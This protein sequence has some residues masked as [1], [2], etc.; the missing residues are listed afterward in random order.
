MKKKVVVIHTGFVSV[1]DLKN[2]FKELLPEVKMQNIVDDSLLEEV[3]A[4]GG[5]TPGVIRRI[6]AYAVQAESTGADLI[7]N[8]C[9][10]VGEAAEI[11]GRLVGIPYVRIDRFMA[12]EAAAIGGRISVVATVPTTLKPSISLIERSAEAAGKKVEIT[13]C[14]V[15]GAFEVLIQGDRQRHNEMVLEKVS[16]VSGKSDAIVL[17]QG[18]MI[19]LLPHL[20]HIRVPVLT[21]P[22]SGVE[23]I[24][25]MLDKPELLHRMKG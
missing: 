17:A 24:R 8:Q 3:L 15:D 20:E 6:C 4:A 5:L 11:A 21:S 12:E 19:C 23:G 2:L 14:L 10:S 7:L 22:R 9:S 1:E 16:D 18:S 13:P 25:R